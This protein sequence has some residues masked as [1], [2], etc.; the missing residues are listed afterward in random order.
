MHHRFL[1]LAATPLVLLAG[2]LPATADTA[3]V[4]QA[5]CFWFGPMGK[6]NAVTN[7]AYPETAA[8][9]WGARFRVPPGAQ[10]TLRG[11][12]PH[13]RFMSLNAYVDQGAVDSLED[14]AI[15]PDKGSTN[16][17]LPKANRYAKKR[18]YQVSVPAPGEPG[19]GANILNAPNVNPGAV[20]ELI[21]RVYSPDRKADG[22]NAAL[23]TPQLRLANG[24]VL[25][26]QALCNAINAEQRYFPFRILPPSMYV[27]LVNTPG[28][29][30]AVNPAFNPIRWERFFNTGLALSIFRYGTPSQDQRKADLAVGDVGGFYDNLAVKYTV[31]PVNAA[32]GPVIVLR[33]KLPTTP[34]TGP[35][36][37]RMQTGQMRYWSICQNTSPSDTAVV[38]CVDDDD[39]RG[40]LGKGRR[41]TVVVS[42]AV[43]KPSN[44]RAKCKVAWLNFGEGLDPAGRRSGT[45]VM[46]N[47]AANPSF[48]QS[49]QRVTP[50]DVSVTSDGT[51]SERDVLGPYLPTGQ[52]TTKAAFEQRGCGKK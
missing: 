45:L 32:H 44:A 20:Q 14:V 29:D 9:Y 31:A 22:A 21:Y 47:L 41:Y 13:A 1:V 19:T 43:D 33:G 4:P 8:T 3:G 23:P 36:V 5:T 51:R 35:K 18:S 27:G 10:L 2:T 34:R 16:P 30:P 52:Y 50:A 40:L 37:R 11:R 24:S 39:L 26:G 38:D 42:R 48:K 12:F 15:Q 6:D 7:K 28:A 17:Y 49:L 25:K 46:R